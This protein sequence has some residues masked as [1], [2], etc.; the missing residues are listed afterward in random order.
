[1]LDRTRDGYKTRLRKRHAT[2]FERVIIGRDY[3]GVEAVLLRAIDR[4]T[5]QQ[6]RRLIFR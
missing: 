4:P 2:F 1:M 3:I 6:L 5:G